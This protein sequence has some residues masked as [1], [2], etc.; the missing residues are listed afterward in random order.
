MTTEV[1]I[2]KSRSYLPH[3]RKIISCVAAR[4]G[5]SRKDIQDAEEAVSTVCLNSIDRA[6]QGHDGNLS[7]K[8]DTSGAYMTVEITDPCIDF[9]PICA[10]ACF[11]NNGGSLE[12]ISRLADSVEFIRGEEGTTIRIVKRA[13]KETA[14]SAASPPQEPALCTPESPATAQ[15]VP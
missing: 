12:S 9:D 15:P 11:G 14:A 13:K 6:S 8:L 1:H 4:L 2:K 10:G 5:M 7:I 3:L